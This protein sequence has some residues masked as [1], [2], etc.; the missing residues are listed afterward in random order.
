MTELPT[1]YQRLGEER[2]IEAIATSLYN[3]METLPEAA[4]IH[5]LHQMGTEE[6]RSRLIAFLT[7][8][9]DGPDRYREQYGEP[10]MRRRHLHIPIGPA[11]RDAWMLCMH[12]SLQEH[13]ADEALRTEVEARLAAFADHMRNRN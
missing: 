6:V 12:K 3:W 2:G 7:R 4:H 1:L 10:M 8:F 11:E 5:S 13:V 9:F